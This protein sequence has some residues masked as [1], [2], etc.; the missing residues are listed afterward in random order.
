MQPTDILMNEHRIIEQ[1]LNCLEK[2]LEQ[3]TT[4]KKLDTKSAKQAIEFFRSLR[5]SLPPRQG[6]G[7]SLPDD[8]GQ[9]LF[10]RV[11]SGGGHAPR[12]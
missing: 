10:G 9:R 7:P 6:R 1:V 12:A 8:A 2:I 3:C 5:R 11:Q 4:E